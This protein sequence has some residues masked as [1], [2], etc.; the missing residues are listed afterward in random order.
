MQKAKSQSK[1]KKS[2]FVKGYFDWM[3]KDLFLKDGISKIEK[4]KNPI[5]QIAAFLLKTQLI[6]FELKQLI[7][8]FDLHLY[9]SNYS[10]ILKRKTKTPKEMDERR[11]TLGKLNKE[12][13]DYEGDFLDDL[14]ANLEELNK[15]RNKFVH[16]LFGPGSKNELIKECKKGLIVA[17]KVIKNIETVNEVLNAHDPLKK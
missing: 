12:L 11:M 16:Q 6:E 5:F 9:F 8:A 13:N 4:F 1:I 2:K 14:K 7:S 3:G 15:F 17:N 10:E